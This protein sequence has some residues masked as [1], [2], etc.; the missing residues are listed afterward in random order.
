VNCILSFSA[1]FVKR[2][3]EKIFPGLRKTQRVNL[4]YGIFGQIKS[5]SGLMS[6]IVRDVPGAVKHKHRLKR[7]WRFL[8]NPRVKPD[9]LRLF[10]ITWV[11]KIFA[12]SR[13]IPVAMDWTT[14]PGNIQC[15]MIAIPF[16]GRAIP[17]LWTIVLHSQI[18]DSQNRIEE[19]LLA[20]LINLVKQS[21]PTKKLLVTADRGFGRATLFQ[22]LLKKHVLF[23]IRVKSDVTITTTKGKRILLRK[24][25]KTL[26][27]NKPVWYQSISYRG[28]G[29][30][31]GVNLAC[32]VAPPKEKGA[33]PDPWFLVTNLRKKETTIA[34]YQQR[35]H[36]E[37]WFKDMKHQL[38]I[39]KLQT[40]NL[41]RV[42]R[43]LF[44]SAVAYGFTMLIGTAAKQLTNVQDQL[45]T[46]GKKVASRIWFALN[47]IKHNLLGSVFW[48][49]V[50][51]KATVP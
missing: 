35:F 6:V 37:E 23:V 19:R 13:I 11:L 33:E 38:G 40:K 4:A 41:M 27:E 12:H 2:L 15:L 49:T 43:L 16:Q 47:I 5:Q 30:V 39:S 17:L 51:L 31:T 7:F 24:R 25:G 26:K 42:R 18:K 28:D 10:W 9:S 50:Y 8:S 1:Q 48:K 3:V 32:V 22:F 29:K 46:G 45:I 14:L 44:V 34:R 20:R 21:A 36:I